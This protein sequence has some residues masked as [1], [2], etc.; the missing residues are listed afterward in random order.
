MSPDTR[1]RLVLWTVF[2][3]GVITFLV[4]NQLWGPR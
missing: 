1:R 4:V 2:M 3:A